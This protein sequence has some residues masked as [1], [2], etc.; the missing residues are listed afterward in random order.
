MHPQ[1]AVGIGS[2]LLEED[3]T[4]PAILRTAAAI[5][6]QVRRFERECT[7][8]VN[9]CDPAAATAAASRR[10]TAA[11]TGA[12]ATIRLDLAAAGDR[13]GAD[14]DGT[15]MGGCENQHVC[16]LQNGCCF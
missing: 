15:A 14:P 4:R 16:S 1:N 10:A 6:L 9:Y 8:A 7:V 5:G 3:R 12:I 11:A 13:T 2:R